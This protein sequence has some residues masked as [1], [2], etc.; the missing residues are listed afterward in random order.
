MWL[1]DNHPVGLPRPSHEER[2]GEGFVAE[3]LTICPLSLEQMWQMAQAHK[4]E[5]TI[6]HDTF[7]VSPEE[8]QDFLTF[9]D[10]VKETKG[11]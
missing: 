3:F 4:I 1:V 6:C 7:T 8:L 10:K 2:T 5:C 11:K 9:V